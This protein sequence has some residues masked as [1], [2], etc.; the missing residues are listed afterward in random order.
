M[1]FWSRKFP[2]DVGRIPPRNQQKK[3]GLVG[4]ASCASSWMRLHHSAA[5]LAL[6]LLFWLGKGQ[7][8][9]PDRFL[10]PSPW[11]AE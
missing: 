8:S 10:R 2:A 9:R 11:I 4:P 6:R 5:R 1:F 7:S 3:T